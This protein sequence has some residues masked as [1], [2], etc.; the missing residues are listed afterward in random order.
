MWMKA[1][2]HGLAVKNINEMQVHLGK[3]L[4]A[5]TPPD[6]LIATNDIGAIAVFSQRRILDTVGLVNP[7]ILPYV[8]SLEQRHNPAP[9]IKY[10]QWKSPQFLV[11]FPAWYPFLTDRTDIFRPIYEVELKDNIVCGANRMVVYR[12]TE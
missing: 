8:R 12:V 1:K 5:H 9:L 10:L 4:K 7:E 2:N 3:W 6:A 11:V